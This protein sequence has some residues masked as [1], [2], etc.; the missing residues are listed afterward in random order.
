MSCLLLSDSSARRSRKYGPS[1][2]LFFGAADGRLA[3]ANGAGPDQGTARARQDREKAPQK[4]LDISACPHIGG[5]QRDASTSRDQNRPGNHH[6]LV[7]PYATHVAFGPGGHRQKATDVARPA[8]AGGRIPARD[9]V[10]GRGGAYRGVVCRVCVVVECQSAK[11]QDEQGR[12]C[13]NTLLHR[14]CANS[15]NCR[16][17]CRFPLVFFF[18][19]FLFFSFSLFLSFFFFFLFLFCLEKVPVPTRPVGWCQLF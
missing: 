13:G 10:G 14:T 19:L 3:L 18:S 5:Q 8:G 9:M 1:P 12:K 2:A 11:A 7:R 4:R 6:D 17:P 16:L 15:P